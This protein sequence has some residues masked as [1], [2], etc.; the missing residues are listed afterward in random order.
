MENL[1]I[2]CANKINK[3]TKKNGLEFEKMKLGIEIFLI[4]ISKL[5]IVISISYILNLFLFTLIIISSFCFIRRT[6]FGLHAMN[7][8]VCTVVTIAAFVGAPYIS[9]YIM[10]NNYMVTLLF[11]I[12]ILILYKYAPSDTE[13]RP[14][15]GEKL[16][17]NLRRDSLLS[18]C[19][20]LLL[21]LVIDNRSIK[22][23]ITLGT[24]MECISIHPLIYKICGRRYKNYE[25]YEN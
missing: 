1:S 24:L 18:G 13:A 14:I 16:R 4:N 15:L 3:Y 10:L 6:A 7:S 12:S 9:K 23:L 21:A 2:K 25:K 8:I 19:T 22:T 11:I 20:L 5:L 17:R